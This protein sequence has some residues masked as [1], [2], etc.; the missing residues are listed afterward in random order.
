VCVALLLAAASHAAY[1]GRNG[2]I[3]DKGYVFNPDGQAF[4][5]L[6][7]VHGVGSEPEA[8]RAVWSRD[9]KR[10]LISTFT[11]I[12]VTDAVGRR[13]NAFPVLRRQSN[14]T[15]AWSRDGSAIVFRHAK[16]HCESGALVVYRFHDRTTTQITPCDGATLPTWSPSTPYIAYRDGYGS[17]RL[18]DARNWTT[19]TITARPSGYPGL[20]P[21]G[22]APSWSP[23]GREIAY[24]NG[25][26]IVAYNI[27]SGETRTLIPPDADPAVRMGSVA[28]SPDGRRIAYTRDAMQ[29]TYRETLYVANID[30]SNAHASFGSGCGCDTG[31]PDWQPS[32]R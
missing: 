18:I 12:Y 15:A 5:K 10:L 17:V 27:S 24:S 7:T 22:G 9:G 23:D 20:W 26:S 11:A 31:P 1:P 19:Q 30:G 8:Q 14:P 2:W 25:H 16:L 4:R 21:Y 29:D 3:A 28:W 13:L 6:P 32:P